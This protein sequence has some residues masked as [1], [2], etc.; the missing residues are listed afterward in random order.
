MSQSLELDDDKGDAAAAP[1][2]FRLYNSLVSCV[3]VLNVIL[4]RH[5]RAAEERFFSRVDR[6]TTTYCRSS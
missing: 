2:Y 4:N 6:A 3:V 5:S 1:V